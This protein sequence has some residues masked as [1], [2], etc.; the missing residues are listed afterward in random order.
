ME[1]KY[2]MLSDGEREY[3]VIF[4]KFFVHAEVF[5]NLRCMIESGPDGFFLTAVSAGSVSLFPEIVCY[6]KS[7]TLGLASRPQD[8][9]II[10]LYNYQ[11]GI[12]DP[13]NAPFIKSLL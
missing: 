12:Y 9:D 6:D 4:P 7:E 11:H 5:R 3:P 2:V 1:F 13:T 8:A 10:L